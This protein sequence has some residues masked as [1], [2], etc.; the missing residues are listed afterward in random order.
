MRC[1]NE[2]S[3]SALRYNGS[4]YSPYIANVAMATRAQLGANVGLENGNGILYYFSE[5]ENGT[6]GYFLTRFV[7]ATIELSFSVNGSSTVIR[8][9]EYCCHRNYLLH[10]GTNE[11]PL[12]Q[13]MRIIIAISESEVSIRITL[14]DDIFTVLES[15][16]EPISITVR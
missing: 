12:G 16:T 11:L 8:Y 4:S 9:I 3:L 10:R 7:N 14:L 2:V 6:G 5:F 1:G 13:F 15:I